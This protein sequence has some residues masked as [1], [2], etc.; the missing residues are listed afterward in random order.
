ML[1]SKWKKLTLWWNLWITGRFS[2]RKLFFCKRNMTSLCLSPLLYIFNSFWL[3]DVLT[4]FNFKMPQT[5][6]RAFSY[7]DHL[8]SWFQSMVEDWPTIPE[9]PPPSPGGEAVE[10]LET[11]TGAFSRIKPVLQICS[12]LSA[13]SFTF[14]FCWLSPTSLSSVSWCWLNFVLKP[15]RSNSFFLGVWD[16][17]RPTFL[18]VT[19]GSIKYQHLK[20]V[21]KDLVN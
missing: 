15:I 16:G 11:F 21:K 2:S 17:C 20:Q 19:L 12:L 8:R 14:G 4:G 18:S 13:A 5:F 1:K 6:K 10:V 9:M 7:R 3:S